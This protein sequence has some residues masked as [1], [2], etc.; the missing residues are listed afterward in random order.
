MNAVTAQPDN[1]VRMAG[2][3]RRVPRA[4]HSASGVP[5]TRFLLEHQSRQPQSGVPTQA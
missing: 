1:Q 2:W 4:R 3:V 5:V